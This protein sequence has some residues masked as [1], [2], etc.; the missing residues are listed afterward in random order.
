MNFTVCLRSYSSEEQRTT[1]CL[2]WTDHV[3]ARKC[4][5][6]MPAGEE[7]LMLGFC[8]WRSG[9]RSGCNDLLET[10]VYP[11][12]ATALCMSEGPQGRMCLFRQQGGFSLKSRGTFHAQQSAICTT[13]ILLLTCFLV[14]S[15]KYSDL[16]QN[17]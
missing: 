12:G 15:Q 14:P 16:I 13:I 17:N 8:D 2:T 4:P 10:D 3:C 7:I 9:R 6:R 1:H 11:R 5:P